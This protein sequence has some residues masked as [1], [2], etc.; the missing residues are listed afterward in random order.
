MCAGL[1]NKRT[2]RE[3]GAPHSILPRKADREP[4]ASLGMVQKPLKKGAK[5]LPK[6]TA[7]NRHGKLVKVKKGATRSRGS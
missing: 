1:I 5:P 4:R 2:R 3:L 7:A 6:P